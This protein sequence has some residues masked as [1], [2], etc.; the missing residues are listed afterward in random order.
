[1]ATTIESYILDN[2]LKKCYIYLFCRE[3]ILLLS[4][5]IGY[6]KVLVSWKKL[7]SINKKVL[8]KK[9]YFVK[10]FNEKKL[11]SPLDLEKEISRFPEI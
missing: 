8:L 6:Y 5:V 4:L 9:N 10:H 7:F 1:M 2:L 3:S 11:F